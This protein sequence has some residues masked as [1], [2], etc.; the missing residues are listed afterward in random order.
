[1]EHGDPVD[2][3]HQTHQRLHI[4]DEMIS[5]ALIIGIGC[6]SANNTDGI[7][8]K[9]DGQSGK[10]KTHCAKTFMEFVPKTHKIMGSCS[11]KVLFYSKITPGTVI[12]SDDIEISADMTATIK[13]S[14]SYYQEE[15][16]HR[17]LN[18]DR[19]PEIHYLPPR[20]MWVLA[21]VENNQ[22]IQLLNRQFGG[23]VDESK[24]QDE[25]V[26]DYQ[27]RV[28]MLG[29]TFQSSI[30]DDILICQEI[31]KDIKTKLF[32]VNIPFLYLIEWNDKNNRRNFP[33]FQDIIRAYAVFRYKQRKIEDNILF[34]D[35]KDYDDAKVLYDSNSANQKTKLSNTELKVVKYLSSV[36]SA[37][38]KDIQDAT[39]FTSQKISQLMNGRKDV[40]DSGLL[41]K[42][43]GLYVEDAIVEADIN[44]TGQPNSE[45]T[46]KFNK[47]NSEIILDPDESIKGRVH[48]NIYRLVG[49]SSNSINDS[50]VYIDSIA[51]EE[52]THQY[53]HVTSM[54][55]NIINNSKTNVTNVPYIPKIHSNDKYQDIL[56]YVLLPKIRHIRNI[57]QSDAESDTYQRCNMDVL[58]GGTMARAI[59]NEDVTWPNSQYADFFK[60]HFSH[61]KSPENSSEMTWRTMQAIPKIK[62]GLNLS[63]ETATKLWQDYCNVRKWGC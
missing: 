10:G 18:K 26:F 25:A 16:E 54:L 53:A 50:S 28:G 49:F 11:D 39:G 61:M 56:S 8:P 12:F 36:S 52:Y 46:V 44:P 59:E 37:S 58:M 35:L 9:L 5:K 17:T 33:M 15:I 2:F 6:Q 63:R 47:I 13:R 19:E 4:G 14:T 30:A 41:F 7:Q 23:S 51:R 55:R 45:E 31:I 21:T 62:S 57:G 20:L 32:H 1:M 43:K 42:L 60:K 22:S 24:E 48:R 38:M 27:V 40:K 3:I 34:A 29:G